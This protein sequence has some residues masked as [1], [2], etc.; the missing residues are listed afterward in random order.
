MCEGTLLVASPLPR[1]GAQAGR[2][3]GISRRPE[4]L[5]LGWARRVGH[6]QL[7][8]QRVQLRRPRTLTGRLGADY[9]VFA[10]RWTSARAVGDGGGD[11]AH[12][13]SRYQS[14][15]LRCCWV[16]ESVRGRHAVDPAR[17]TLGGEHL[18]SV[19]WSGLWTRPGAPLPQRRR[20]ILAGPV[21]LSDPSPRLRVSA[22]SPC[23]ARDRSRH[24]RASRRHGHMG[25]R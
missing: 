13:T 8:V 18:S 3:N 1:N 4:S 2:L 23:E 10:A 15:T 21:Q 7:P 20:T 17:F 6:V 19:G 12:P 11:A 14:R 16:F 25:L 22:R 5:A 9:A 24:Q